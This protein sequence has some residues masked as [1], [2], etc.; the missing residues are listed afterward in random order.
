MIKTAFIVTREDTQN[1]KDT[2]SK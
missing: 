2:N 1:N